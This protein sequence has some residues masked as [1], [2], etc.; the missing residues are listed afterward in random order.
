MTDM[1]LPHPQSW[2]LLN[3][4]LVF[5]MWAIMMVAMMVPSAAPMMLMFTALNRSR[6]LRQRPY[7][8]VTV[9]L[10]GYLAIWTGFSAIATV[11][12]WRLQQMALLSPAMV[13][14][15]A[16]FG[17]ALLVAAGV[18]QWTPLKRRCLNHCRS[19]LTFLQTE[20]REG[21]T[22]AFIMG[23]RHGASVPVA[24]GF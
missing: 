1:A 22:G 5:A 23:I 18:F 20:W 16:L 3:L 15:S 11:A 4:G 17:G 2:S 24:A 8:P 10:A 21:K 13:S 7:V 6:R 9:F 12:Q 14:T 19:P